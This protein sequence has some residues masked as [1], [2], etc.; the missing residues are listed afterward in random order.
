MSAVPIDDLLEFRQQHGGEYQ[1][2]ASNVRTFA[3]E[4]ASTPELDRAALLQSRRNE[5]AAE[6]DRLTHIART[7][8]RQPVASVSVG[9]AGAVLAGAHGDWSADTLS[10]LTGIGGAGGRPDDASVYSYLFG[11]G[12]RFGTWA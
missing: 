10:L 3:H 8:W 5:L 12:S 1:R 11:T 7:W 4:V 6:A 9:L 2:Y